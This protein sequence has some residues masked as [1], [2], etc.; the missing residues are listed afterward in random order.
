[1]KLI[2]YTGAVDFRVLASED[3][4]V[5]EVTGFRKTIFPVGV[6]VE[7]DDE[8]AQALIDNPDIFGNFEVIENAP[9]VIDDQIAAIAVD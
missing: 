5:A 7:V 2:K 9:E 4:K 1:M 6:G 3:L 8:V